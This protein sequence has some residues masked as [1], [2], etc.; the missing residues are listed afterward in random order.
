MIDDVRNNLRFSIN[1]EVARLKAKETKLNS[2]MDNRE[3]E[4]SKLCL[5]KIYTILVW[6][7]IASMTNHK[8]FCRDIL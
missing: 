5:L 8:V 2:R 6:V 7:T 1:R 3:S 4:V